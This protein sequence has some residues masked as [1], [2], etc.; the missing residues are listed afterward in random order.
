MLH[1]LRWFLLLLVLF[2]GSAMARQSVWIVLSKDGGVYSETAAMLQSELRAVGLADLSIAVG[3]WT[4]LKTQDSPSLI[5]TLGVTA[6]DEV[7]GQPAPD[8]PVI[9][10]LLPSAS[11]R[12]GEEK[13]HTRPIT[14]VFIDPPPGRFFDFLLKVL[15]GARRVGVL[16]GPVTEKLLPALRKSAQQRSMTLVSASTVPINGEIYPALK[17]VLSDSDVLLALPEPSVYSNESLPRILLATYRA[18]IPM[19]GFAPGYLTAGAVAALYVTPVQ[20]VRETAQKALAWS[21]RNDWGPP[22]APR[23]LSVGVNPRVAESLGLSLPSV[24][25]LTKE[26]LASG[27]AP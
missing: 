3:T 19:V 10:S 16:A 11:F 18:R 23:E 2:A 17:S 26:M 5:I 9:A 8:V 20:V 21:R 1:C 22:R 25:A 24:D 14:A 27:G 12:A 4:N 15:P 6:F 13:L 7:M